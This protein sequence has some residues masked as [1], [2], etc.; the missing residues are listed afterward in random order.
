MPGEVT[1]GGR[2]ILDP[3]HR[4]NVGDVISVAVPPPEPAAAAG[5]DIPLTIVHED[6]DVIVIDKPAGLVVHP[7][8]GNPDRDA[9]QRPDRPLRRQA[10][11]GSAA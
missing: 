5:E 3:G 7:A 8:A 11:R 6:A 9:G 4:V 2:T 10:C 1:I